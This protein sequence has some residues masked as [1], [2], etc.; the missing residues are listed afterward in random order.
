MAK[1]N[2]SNSR[3]P[4]MFKKVLKVDRLGTGNERIR[5]KSMDHLADH[6][7][8]GPLIDTC[9]KTEKMRRNRGQSAAPRYDR[10]ISDLGWKELRDVKSRHPVVTCILP[11]VSMDFVAS[12]LLAV[13][14]IP[15]ITEGKLLLI[16][17]CEG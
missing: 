3:S 1:Y 15:L 10:E 17:L 4:M 16:V 14:A 12:C 7:A 13:G 11:A 6:L 2:A 9:D 8:E 5:S